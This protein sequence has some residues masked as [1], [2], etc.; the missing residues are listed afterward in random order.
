MLRRLDR[1][2][3][4]RAVNNLDYRRNNIEALMARMLEE[5]RA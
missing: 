2:E 1:A 5:R 4:Q 3:L